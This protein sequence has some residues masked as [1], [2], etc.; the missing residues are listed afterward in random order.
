MPGTPV[1][2]T[3]S[4]SPA[5]SCQRPLK[6]KLKACRRSTVF[7]LVSRPM[8]AEVA[9][10]HHHGERSVA[11]WKLRVPFAESLEFQG[12][13][14]PC[15]QFYINLGLIRLEYGQKPTPSRNRR[16]KASC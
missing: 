6:S 5:G 15:I 12:Y 4:L 8:G 16:F 13:R 10:F 1:G 3:R 2:Q 9:L 11:E 14:H 7:G